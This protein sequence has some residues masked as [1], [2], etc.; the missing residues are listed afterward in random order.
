M[1]REWNL[2]SLALVRDQWGRPSSSGVVGLGGWLISGLV[3]VDVGGSCLV[4]V[5]EGSLD[6]VG[7]GSGPVG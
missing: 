4:V 5:R 7:E 2:A 1:Q 6:G 3:L